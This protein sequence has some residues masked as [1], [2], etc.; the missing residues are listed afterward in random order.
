MTWHSVK[1]NVPFLAVQ[2][3]DK[4][5]R[6]PLLTACQWGRADVVMLFLQR[7]AN[8]KARST[9]DET[10]LDVSPALSLC[11]PGNKKAKEII[12]AFMADRKGD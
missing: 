8:P 6:T 3:V 7:G 11:A 1:F 9:L 4:V 10:A 5:G 2:T 12:A